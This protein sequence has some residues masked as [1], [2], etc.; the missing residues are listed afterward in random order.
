MVKL[1]HGNSSE[2]LDKKSENPWGSISVQ[3]NSLS[4]L[5]EILEKSDDKIETYTVKQVIV[6]NPKRVDQISLQSDSW[7][8]LTTL[9]Y[10]GVDY[11]GFEVWQKVREWVDAENGLYTVKKVIVG[12]S[13][14]ADQVI[15]EP[16]G[17]GAKMTLAYSGVDY[18][19]FEVWQ[20]LLYRKQSKYW[21]GKEF[22][23]V[24]QN[25]EWKYL[26]VK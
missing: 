14:M 5:S 4:N 7:R 16:Y 13:I 3:G 18:S 26:L 1:K 8:G 12:D 6:G 21:I 22:R 24:L 23:T 10:S 19:G 20:K 25:L 17:W 15:L 2:I 9:A 11:S